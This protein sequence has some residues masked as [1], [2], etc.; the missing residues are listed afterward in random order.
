LPSARRR[1]LPVLALAGR[2]RACRH[3]QRRLLGQHLRPAAGPNPPQ[4]F[5][6]VGLIV[7]E[8]GDQR[9][10]AD[11]T[12]L[13]AGFRL[14]GDDGTNRVTVDRERHHVRFVFSEPHA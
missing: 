1:R 6:I 4:L 14:L 7:G 13:L 10:L 9:I 3:R 12:Q 2:R 5:P 8:P 11:V